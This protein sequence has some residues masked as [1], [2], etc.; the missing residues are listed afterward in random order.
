MHY[1]IIIPF[2]NEAESL[3][4]LHR[5][6][7]DTL[8]AM[9][10]YELVFIDDGSTDNSYS[11]AEKLY[12]E[13]EHIRLARLRRNFGKSVALAAGFGAATGDVI[14][15]IDADLQDEPREIP[16][17]VAMLDHADVVVGWKERRND[18]WTKTFPSRVFNGIGRSLFKLRLH[19][20]NCGL[21][22]MRK[23]VA[24]EIPMYGEMHRFVPVLAHV[25]GFRVAEKSVLHHERKFGVSKYGWRRFVRGSFDLG[26]VWFLS[27]YRTTPMHLFGS[28][29]ALFIGIGVLLAGYLSI[30]HFLGH[31]IGDRPLLFFA[32]FA[33]IAG[34]QLF[35]TGFL[36][37]LLTWMQGTRPAPIRTLLDHTKKQDS[38]E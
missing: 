27:R 20:L 19:D 29:G 30:E 13:D 22:V 24:K 18:P 5:Q 8:R 9:G 35:F 26:T 6:L 17:L 2:F 38:G 23:E 7:T 16:A 28:L 10:S 25:R 12:R 15:T 33:I 11:V 32:F 37:E 14:V 4:E 31:A 3:E 21:K 34:L 36:A 1:S